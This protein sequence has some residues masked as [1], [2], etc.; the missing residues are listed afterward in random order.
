MADLTVE[1]LAERLDKLEKQNSELADSNA[2]LVATNEELQKTI[3]T[4]TSL[5]VGAKPEKPTIPKE[6][7]TVD[8]K[9]YNFTVALF[10]PPN[11]T[12]PVTAKE[13][14]TDPKLLAE[15]VKIKGQQILKEVL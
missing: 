8:K 7:V 2:K 5:E 6:S 3:G 11:A 12:E 10:Y 1:I 14:S 13:A 4:A 9:E 15:I